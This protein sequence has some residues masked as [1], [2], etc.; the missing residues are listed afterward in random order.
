MTNQRVGSRQYA[1]GSEQMANSRQAVDGKWQKTAYCLLLTAYCL[2]FFNSAGLAQAVDSTTD[3]TTPNG[4]KAVHKRVQGNEVVAIR[5]YFKGGVRNITA[6]NAG[7]EAL[8]WEAAQ[9]GTKNFSKSQINRELAKMGTLI[10]SAAGYDYTFV[11]M[12]CVRQH[13]DRSWQIL[14]D[15]VLNPLFDE[16]EVALERER[17]VNALRQEADD[18]DS[19]VTTLSDRLLYAGHPYVNRPTG[20]VESLSSLK[21]ADLKAYHAAHLTASRLL[22]VVVG[23]VTLDDVKRKA[24]ASFG[25]LP[26]GDYKPEPPAGFTRANTPEFEIS[27]RQV[28]TNYVRGVFAAPSIGDKDYAALMVAMN[29]LNSQFLE[30]V[31]YK[32]NLSYAPSADLLAQ[33]ANTGVIYVTTPK[34]NE[35]IK[36]MF[37]EIARIQQNVIRDKP[38][39]DIINGFLTTYYLKLETNSAQASRLGEYEL[40]GGG[41]RKALAWLEEVQKVTPDDI[42]RVANTY[43]KNFHF[44]VIGEA[45]K[46]DRSLFLQGKGGS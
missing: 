12:Q 33:G 7:I 15:I 23:N 36:I 2:L 18:P 28:P 38:L 6:K 44:A 8:M 14:A 32:R 24:E 17:I 11:A 5:I 9:H 16:P 31:R 30:E 35:A 46:F 25:K 13:F 45:S 40:L 29:I 27:E 3:F 39:A 19:Y 43:L 10:G 4:L 42:Q 41:W 1:V 37:E 26:Q 20:T 34:P 21:A 22:L